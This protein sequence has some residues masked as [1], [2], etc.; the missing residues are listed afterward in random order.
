MA[1]TGH[2][3]RLTDTRNRLSSPLGLGSAF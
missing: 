3:L 2:R 1:G